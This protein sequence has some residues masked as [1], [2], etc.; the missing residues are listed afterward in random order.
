MYR[1]SLAANVNIFMDSGQTPMIE[2]IDK[3]KRRSFCH[4]KSAFECKT[5]T[6]CR[7]KRSLAVKNDSTRLQLDCR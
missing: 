6:I 7:L 3:D 1:R 5:S 4:L 2:T